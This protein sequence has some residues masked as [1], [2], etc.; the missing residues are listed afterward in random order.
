MRARVPNLSAVCND[1]RQSPFVAFVL[2]FAKP[3]STQHRVNWT[4]RRLGPAF[5]NAG[6]PR[7]RREYP[8]YQE[9]QL[10]VCSV[11]SR[12]YYGDG[13]N[14]VGDMRGWSLPVLDPSVFG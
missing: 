13:V 2:V 9:S 14:W 1:L 12:G 6:D 5:W 10:A 8:T 3:A 7:T 4:Q 11:V